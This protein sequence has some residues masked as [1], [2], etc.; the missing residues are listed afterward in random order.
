MAYGRESYPGFDKP[1]PRLV[2]LPILLPIGWD[3]GGK[4]ISCGCP[5]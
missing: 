5:G 2:D 4:A 1:T 3:T